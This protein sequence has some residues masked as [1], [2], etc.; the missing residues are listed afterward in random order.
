VHIKGHFRNHNRITIST[1]FYKPLN[2]MFEKI[3]FHNKIVCFK[4]NYF[5]I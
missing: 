3:F 4:K 5:G 1:I 2:S